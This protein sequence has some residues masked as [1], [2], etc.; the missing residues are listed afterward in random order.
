MVVRPSAIAVTTPAALTV[1]TL[2]FVD[3]QLEAVVRSCTL[4]SAKVTMADNG[5]VS[6]LA[7][8]VIKP[9]IVMPV[10][11]LAVVLDVLAA[12]GDGFVI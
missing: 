10:A 3:D 1:A 9:L 5:F 8:R 4:P 6:P 12:V 11:R 7:L 2:S